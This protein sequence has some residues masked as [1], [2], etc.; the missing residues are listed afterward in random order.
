MYNTQKQRE[1]SCMYCV[2][3]LSKITNNDTGHIILVLVQWF[4]NDDTIQPQ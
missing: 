3:E 2:I 1:R 4:S